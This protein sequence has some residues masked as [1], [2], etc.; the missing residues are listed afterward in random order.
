VCFLHQ[1]VVHEQ[2]PPEQVLGTPERE[3]TQQFLRR[4]VQADRL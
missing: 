3:R 2:G 4:I 1:G